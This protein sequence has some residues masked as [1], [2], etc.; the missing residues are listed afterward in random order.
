MARATRLAGVAAALAAGVLAAAGPA[1]GSTVSME[2]ATN[3]DGPASGIFSFTA[4]GNEANHVVVNFE[5]GN[6]VVV[7]DSAGVAPSGR[8]SRPDPPDPDVV[9]CDGRDSVAYGTAVMTLGNLNDSLIVRAAAGLTPSTSISAGPGNDAVTGG[10][11]ADSLFGGGGAD[12]LRAGAGADTI[13]GE[14]GNDRLE[15]GTGNDR[16]DGGPGNDRLLGGS[17][18]D[19]MDG[20]SGRDVLLT[21]PG[22]DRALA[23]GIDLV[24]GHRG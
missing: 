12:V 5:P 3:P 7:R 24:D 13:F 19:A 9:V 21:G 4:S 15:G 23:D 1:W 22:L 14:T 20:G 17:G 2:E 8:C 6:R 18:N 11:G 16:L 10:P